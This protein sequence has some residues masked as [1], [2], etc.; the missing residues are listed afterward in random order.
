MKTATIEGVR[1]PV[2]VTRTE[3]GATW[4]GRYIYASDDARPV[5]TTR[6]GVRCPLCDRN[7][8]R[9]GSPQPLG[10]VIHVEGAPRTEG[11][12]IVQD[13]VFTPVPRGVRVLVCRR[14]QVYFTVKPFTRIPI[15]S[16]SQPVIRRGSFA[17]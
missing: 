2:D 6:T 16:P 7:F 9:K 12:R 10:R 8:L 1:S 3:H 14:C 15:F 5:F 13:A 11:E 4:E 17:D